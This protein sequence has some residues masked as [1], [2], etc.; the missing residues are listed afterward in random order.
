M[1]DKLCAGQRRIFYMNE[2]ISHIWRQQKGTMSS[3]KDTQT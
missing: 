2:W 1:Y 3:I